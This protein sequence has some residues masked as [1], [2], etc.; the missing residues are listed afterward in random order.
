MMILLLARD[1]GQ[2][3]CCECWQSNRVEKILL[4]PVLF[5]K[6]KIDQEEKK[7]IDIFEFQARPLCQCK[8]HVK[9]FCHFGIF[10]HRWIQVIFPQ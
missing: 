4:I 3:P 8:F 6:I 2:Q 1:M 5:E 10:N 9:M 7:V